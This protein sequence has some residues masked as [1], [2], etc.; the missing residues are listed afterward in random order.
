MD[1][2]LRINRLTPLFIAVY[3]VT[4]LI[5]LRLFYLQV[6]A[7]GYYEEVARREQYG[8]TTLPARRGEILI[9]DYHS[10]EIYTLASNTTLEMIYADPTLIKEPDL[11]AETLAPLLFDLTTEQE[12]DEKRYEEEYEAILKLESIPLREEALSKLALKTDEELGTAY[13][14]TLEDTLADKTRDLILI[15]ADLDETQ[16]E[17]IKALNLRNRVH[18]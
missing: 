16:Q 10:G 18:Q 2:H 17:E 14:Q 5:L 15:T 7:H 1:K 9:E 4:G 6:I 12:L 8:Y 3:M 13:R 11:V